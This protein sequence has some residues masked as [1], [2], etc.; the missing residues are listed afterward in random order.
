MFYTDVRNDE[1]DGNRIHAI[2][3]I[4]IAIAVFS[5]AIKSL[6]DTVKDLKQEKTK[7]EIIIKNNLTSFS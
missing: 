1:F 2:I 7:T 6:V 5:F 3:Y 4:L